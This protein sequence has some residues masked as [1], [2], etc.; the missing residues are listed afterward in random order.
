MPR[1]AQQ[2]EVYDPIHAETVRRASPVVVALPRPEPEKPAPRAVEPAPKAKSAP[3][4]PAKAQGRDAFK[5]FKVTEDEDFEIADFI[6]GLQQ[7]SRSKVT[8]SVIARALFQL[9]MHA[10]EEIVAE[11]AKADS[12]PRPANKDA[13]S[14]A[15]F[16]EFWMLKLSAALRK[17]G[18]PQ[19][20]LPTRER[21][22]G[23]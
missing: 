18:P 10:R 22:G 23:D 20:G 7:K 19:Q 17:A 6:R 16:E 14:M 11:L 5:H 1:K 21:R 8:L 15:D 9:A 2:E 4:T 3:E 13:E 12:V